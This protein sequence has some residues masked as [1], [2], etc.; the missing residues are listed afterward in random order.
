MNQMDSKDRDIDKSQF[1]TLLAC[2]ID[3]Y[4][5]IFVVAGKIEPNKASDENGCHSGW[6][7]CYYEVI[8]SKT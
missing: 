2:F 1:S 4:V 6:A 5:M 7:H 8:I 3:S